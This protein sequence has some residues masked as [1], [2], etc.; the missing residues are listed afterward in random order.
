MFVSTAKSG[1]ERIS[2]FGV[3]LAIPQGAQMAVPVEDGYWLTQHDDV[4]VTFEDDAERE[5]CEGYLAHFAKNPLRPLPRPATTSPNATL[6]MDG[7]AERHPVVVVNPVGLFAENQAS[8]FAPPQVAFVPDAEM[9]RDIVRQVLTEAGVIPPE[10]P[11]KK[12]G[13]RAVETE[14]TPDAVATEE[15][16]PP[17]EG[18]PDEGPPAEPFEV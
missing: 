17:V 8:P 3:R 5:K 18:P 7:S 15:V 11:A 4:T 10:A 6:A 9:L 2:P 1:V 13:K 14:E 16:A 12:R